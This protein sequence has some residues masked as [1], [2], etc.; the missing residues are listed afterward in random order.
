M[1]EATAGISAE[2]LTSPGTALGTV[3]YMSPE[4]VRGKELDAR[5]KALEIDDTVAEAHASLVGLRTRA[6]LCGVGPEEPGAERA[7]RTKAA[8]RQRYVAPFEI[9]RC[10]LRHGRGCLA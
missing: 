9:A 10:E 1:T 2:Q 3:A 5:T 8:M 4:Q 6:C 7:R